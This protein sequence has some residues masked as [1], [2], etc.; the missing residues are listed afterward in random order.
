LSTKSTI[1]EEIECKDSITLLH[2]SSGES[3]H[4]TRIFFSFWFMEKKGELTSFQALVKLKL[5]SLPV[6]SQVMEH[7]HSWPRNTSFFSRSITSS[8]IY[9]ECIPMVICRIT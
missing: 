3:L 4:D 6:D 1:P 2:F 5:S 7:S 8:M 9:F